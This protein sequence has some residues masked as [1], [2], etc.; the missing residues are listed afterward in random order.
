MGAL[1][2]DDYSNS[3]ERNRDI[4]ISKFLIQSTPVTVGQYYSFLKDTGYEKDYK[5]E[6][7]DGN[8]WVAGPHFEFNGKGDDYPVVGVSFIDAENY[9][10]WLSKKYGKKFRL[11]TEAEF[12]YAAKSN[13]KCKSECRYANMAQELKIVRN[14]GE[15]PAKG[16][17]KIGE[18]VKT[19]SGLYGMHGAIWQ[20][21]SD[22]FFYYDERDIDNPKGPKGEPLYA[23]WKGEKW[24]P[25]KTIR[26]GSFSYPFYYARCSDRH[27]S[28]V[29]DRNYNVGFR[30]CI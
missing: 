23:P 9:I 25:G 8:D 15:V 13:C 3:L 2:G 21:C 10:D 4:K 28:K 24:S 19:D 12:E 29:E 11:P 18:T 5:I 27:Y 1:N 16:P 22:W 30:L 17:K 7:W 6:V 20:W 26:G 14:E